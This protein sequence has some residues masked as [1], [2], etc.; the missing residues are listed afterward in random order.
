MATGRRHSSV[1]RRAGPVF[2]VAYRTYGYRLREIAE[3]PGRA[4]ATVSRAI[5]RLE[6]AGTSRRATIRGQ[7]LQ[8]SKPHPAGSQ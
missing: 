5:A 6:E 1:L 2:L 7:V 4:P 3:S 8:V